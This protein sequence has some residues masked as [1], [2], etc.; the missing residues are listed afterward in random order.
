MNKTEWFLNGDSVEPSIGL[1]VE[2][3]LP[4]FIFWELT[5]LK[6]SCLQIGSNN[7]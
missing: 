2:Y 5:D 1:K 7:V 3:Y 6:F 4:L